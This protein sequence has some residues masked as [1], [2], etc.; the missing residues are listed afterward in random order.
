MIISDVTIVRIDS[1]PK[2]NNEKVEDVFKFVKGL[3]EEVPELEIPEVVID[4]A[5]R[6]GPDYTEKKT[7]KVCKSIF[8]RF[9]TF[10]HRTAF[11]RARKSIGNRAQVR[12]DLT[13]WRYDILKARNEYIK[14]IGHTPKFCYADINCRMKNKWGDNSEEFFESLQDLKDLVD[15]NCWKLEY[16][17]FVV[18]EVYV[19]SQQAFTCSGMVWWHL[20]K[21]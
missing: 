5:H 18:L 15:E 9:T 11:Y 12:L 8:V 17:N 14:S 19:Y 7:Q 6:I 20:I 4:R 10:R 16:V 1:V 3:I 13:K 2:Q 21:L